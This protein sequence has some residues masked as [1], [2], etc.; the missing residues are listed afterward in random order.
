M[1]QAKVPN[2]FL[3]AHNVIVNVNVNAEDNSSPI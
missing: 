3:Q 2:S 1:Y